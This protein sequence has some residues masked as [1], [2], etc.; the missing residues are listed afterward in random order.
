MVRQ[1]AVLCRLS[2]ICLDVPSLRSG[3]QAGETAVM[4]LLSPLLQSP[5]S[6]LYDDAGLAANG[7]EPVMAAYG[8]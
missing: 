2:P 8:R 4:Q 7:M 3:I 6:G 5:G 1:E